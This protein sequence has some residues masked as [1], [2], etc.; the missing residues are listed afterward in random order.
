[1]ADTLYYKET[2]CLSVINV[3]SLFYCYIWN[4]AGYS[5]IRWLHIQRSVS[6][7]KWMLRFVIY[8]CILLC[9]VF[10]FFLAKSSVI[11]RLIYCRI[12]SHILIS[13]FIDTGGKRVISWHF[14]FTW[15]KHYLKTGNPLVARAFFIS[16]SIKT[17]DWKQIMVASQTTSVY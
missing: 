12:F 9:I 7:I 15:M 2:H 17:G 14:L 11:G 6:C 5:K 1:M 8:L 16:L 3:C 13:C 10:L 4:N